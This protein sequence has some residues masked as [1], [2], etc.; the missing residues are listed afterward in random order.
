MK[1]ALVIGGALLRAVGLVAA[2]AIVVFL[3]LRTVPGDVVDVMAAQ[4]D[5]DRKS[6]RLNSSHT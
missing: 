2:I 4:G 3:L 6:T 1:G 5:L